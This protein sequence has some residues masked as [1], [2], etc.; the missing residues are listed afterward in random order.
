[1]PTRLSELVAK[2]IAHPPSGL[3][4]QIAYEVYMGSSAYAVSS[5]TSD[6]D[7]Y[8]FA[9]PNKDLIF[10]HLRGEIDGFGPKGHRFNVYTEYG[11]KDD[12]ACGGEGREY[13]YSI[14]SIVKFFSLCSENNP[15]MVDAL[16]IPNRCILHMTPIGQM[17][18]E[19]RHLFLTKR[20]YHTCKGYA[21]QQLHKL[22]IKNPSPN[23]KRYADVI[24]YGFDPKFAYHIVRLVDQC[25][26]ILTEGD[27]DL[28]RNCEKLKSIRRGEW[29]VEQIEQYFD[30]ME[31]TLAKVVEESSLPWGPDMAAIKELLLDCLEQHFGTLEGCVVRSDAATEFFREV[32]AARD[33]YLKRITE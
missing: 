8:G 25:H 14:Y 6:L 21:Y 7:V 5:D 33:R 28:E 17:V 32:D 24:K 29:T 11:L 19:K 15:N 9:I 3:D 12:V 20:I 13:D 2:G 23:S 26:Q 16:F 18:R 22:R 31:A 10:P 27:L 1:M 30:R 4:Q